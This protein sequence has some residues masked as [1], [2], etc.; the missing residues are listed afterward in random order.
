M[1]KRK[2]GKSDLEIVPLVLGGNVFGWTIDE[3]KSFEILDAFVDRG[4][5]CIDTADIYAKWVPGNQGGESEAII[6]KWAARSGNRNKVVLAT[7]VGMEM[8]PDKK[9]LSKKYIL[10][11]VEQ[12]LKRLQTD[13]IDLYQSHQDD[14]STPIEE[15]LEAY[16]K[17]IEQGKVRVIG[18]SNFK[19]ERLSESI[20]L[21]EKSGLPV[22]RTL[23]P[24]YNMVDRKDY[25]ENLAP[26]AAKYGLGVI[27]YFSLAAGFLTGKYQSVDDT[28]AGGRGGMV[29][30][31]FDERGL[32]I[33]KALRDV[34]NDKSAEQASVALAWLLA[35]PTITAPIA[36]ATSVKQLE[37]L[38]AAVDLK[39]TDAQVK[40]LTDASA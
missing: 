1:Q 35:Q 33:L 4:F 12:S 18:A 14:E 30:K 9:G 20:E 38:F 39:L 15:T 21:A 17:L 6:G 28:K 24:D 27:P 29:A 16:A 26:V 11:A 34:A 8:P 19:A 7:K 22:Y 3:T 10:E 25:E 31:Y 23:Q 32:R 36:S 2:L 5:N 37:A 40:E 13:H